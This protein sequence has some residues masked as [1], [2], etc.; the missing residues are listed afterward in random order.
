MYNFLLWIKKNFLFLVTLWTFDPEPVVMFIFVIVVHLMKNRDAY[1]YDHPCY[2][3]RDPNSFFILYQKSWYG[4]K[5]KREWKYQATDMFITI[6]TN[7]FIPLYFLICLIN[8]LP[9]VDLNWII[10]PK[11]AILQILHNKYTIWTFFRAVFLSYIYRDDDFSM[12]YYFYVHSGIYF[13][14]TFMLILLR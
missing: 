1:Y 3:Y 10:H 5:W 11:L 14:V 4:K 8:C 2:K 9:M 7:Y 13:L 12:F 6:L